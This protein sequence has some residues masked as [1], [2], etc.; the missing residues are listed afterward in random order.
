MGGGFRWR[1]WRAERLVPGPDL[2]AWLAA[3]PPA[4]LGDGD[5]AAVAGSWRRVASWAQS[6]ELAAVAQLTSRAAAS[7]EHAS[8][9]PDGRPS[10]VTASAAAQVALELTMSQYGA[11]AWADLAVELSWRL[12]GTG[13]ALEAGVI[14]LARARL[15]AE[16]T[17][18]LGD[19]AARAVEERV[20]PAAG[21]QTTGMLRAALRRAVIAADPQGAEERR[22]DAE[23]RAQVVLYPDQDCTATLAGQR[24][25]A[26]HAAAMARIKAMARALKASGAGGGIDLL[27]AQIYLG[28]LL[29]TLPL[30]PPAEGAPPASLPATALV[31]IPVLAIRARIRPLAAAMTSPASSRTAPPR[32]APAGTGMMV[33]RAMAG[34]ARREMAAWP[35]TA[36]MT[37]TWPVTCRR[38]AT[39]TR[40]AT[41]T[42]TPARM[43]ARQATPAGTATPNV[44]T[45]AGSPRTGQPCPRSSRPPSPAPAPRSR[46]GAQLPGYSTSHCPGRYWPGSAPGLGRIGPIP[47]SQ[48]RHLAAVAAR[49]PGTQWRIIVTTTE[50]YA[51]AVT[52]IPAPAAARQNPAPGKDPALKPD[53]AQAPA[54]GS[55][56]SAGSP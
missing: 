28:L 25:P 9:S 30:I 22:K 44:M 10:Q 14:D 4:G 26:I 36:R 40:P 29:G 2:A 37:M 42:T 31:M 23:R 21:D 41:T 53:P 16:A 43:T 7:D 48:A 3:A 55:A 24:L 45:T 6:R 1:R 49:D 5:L 32:A 34:P 51:L 18:P 11:S 50:G 47:A 15:I 39:R 33:P 19:E 54:P 8:I 46:T 56:W 13:A 27:C 35:V 17:A 38:P 12:P 20:L 52:R